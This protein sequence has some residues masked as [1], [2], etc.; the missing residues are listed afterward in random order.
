MVLTIFECTQTQKTAEKSCC[1]SCQES[2][3]DENN[4]ILKK[5]LS[6]CHICMEIQYK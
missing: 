2:S 3:A 1:D 5:C 4:R 6:L